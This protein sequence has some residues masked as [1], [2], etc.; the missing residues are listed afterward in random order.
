MRLSFDSHPPNGADHICVP[1]QGNAI[2]NYR[3]SDPLPQVKLHV[4]HLLRGGVAELHLPL[5]LPLLL[6]A[7]H[8]VRGVLPPLFPPHGRV[9]AV[10]QRQLPVSSAVLSVLPLLHAASDGRGRV[11][12]DR[13]VLP[14]GTD[15]DDS[16]PG[17]RIQLLRAGDRL[18]GL[19]VHALEDDL[20]LQTAQ[21]AGG[22]RW[23][24]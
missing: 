21:E 15:E 22:S 14:A 8:S 9:R 20:G 1:P 12:V 24:E 19:D 23:V 4:A 3:N 13:L 16:L 2:V 10:L 7:P 18:P 11:R 6:P 5:F 17:K